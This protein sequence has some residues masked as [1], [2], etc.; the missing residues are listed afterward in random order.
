MMKERAV[1]IEKIGLMAVYFNNPDLFTFME[2]LNTNYYMNILN[3]NSKVKCK[4]L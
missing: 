4:R 2:Q 3:E 1:N